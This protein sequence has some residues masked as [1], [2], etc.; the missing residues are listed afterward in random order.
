[1]H[2]C[3]ETNRSTAM[4][5]NSN[6]APAAA[7]DS[8]QLGAA[9]AGPEDPCGPTVWQ[10][11]VSQSAWYKILTHSSADAGAGAGTPAHAGA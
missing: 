10:S 9:A 4:A 2:L 11:A 3:T 1:V 7:P 6:G 8:K 5:S